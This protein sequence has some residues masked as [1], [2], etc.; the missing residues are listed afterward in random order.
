MRICVILR[1]AGGAAELGGGEGDIKQ[2]D[3][4]VS[5]NISGDSVRKRHKIKKNVTRL[6]R[7]IYNIYIEE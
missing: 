7:I 6:V 1:P 5:L 2:S 3:E 4:E